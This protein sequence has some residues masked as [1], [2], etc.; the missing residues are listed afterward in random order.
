MRVVIIGA[1]YAGLAC[2]LRLSHQAPRAAEITLINASPLF[3]ER[4]R[5]HEQAAGSAP[6]T[7][8]LAT[9][10]RGTR[11]RLR[12]GHVEQIDLA[13]RTLRLGPEQLAWDHLVL[14]L[15]SRVAVN[16]VP[17]AG[18]HAFTLDATSTGWLAQVVP[19]IAARG[20]HVAVVGGGLTGIEAAAELAERYPG[21]RLSLITRG[22]FA[23]DLPPK[24]RVHLCENL[25]RAGVS[26]REHVDVR[27]VEAG[28]LQT[29]EGVIPFDAC[30][31]SAGFEAAGSARALALSADASGR[32]YVDAKLRAEGRPDVYVV[33]DLIAQREPRGAP[34]PMG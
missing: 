11:V 4:I 1:G 19:R 13:A 26:L 9:F 28:V 3:V 27:A 22:A 31:W 12:V 33:G 5:L 16:R 30:V 17:G 32:I 29:A 18:A 15:G 25:R 24:A 23:R 2:A 7:F 14:A 34:L 6:P 8:G 21:L 10:L 20:G